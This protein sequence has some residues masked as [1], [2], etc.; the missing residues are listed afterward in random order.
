MILVTLN[1]QASAFTVIEYYLCHLEI[2]FQTE[3]EASENLSHTN[4]GSSGCFLIGEAEP[5]DSF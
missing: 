1:K 4:L 5:M 2:I 3:Q